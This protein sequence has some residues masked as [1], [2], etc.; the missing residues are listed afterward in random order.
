MECMHWGSLT[1]VELAAWVQ[2]VGSVVAIFVAVAVPT[3]SS[4]R[5]KR[6]RKV[7]KAEKAKN[8]ILSVYAPLLNMHRSLNVFLSNLSADHEDPIVNWDPHD[9]DFQKHIPHLLAAIPAFDNLPP[10]VAKPLRAMMATLI[11]MNHFLESIPAIEASGS[12][13]F[14]RNNQDDIRERAEALQKLTSDSLAACSG[15]LHK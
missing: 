3:I 14:F 7:E 2:A 9:G 5:Q 1:S 13:A 4:W 15:W 6:S 8:T 12:P 11:D 10:G